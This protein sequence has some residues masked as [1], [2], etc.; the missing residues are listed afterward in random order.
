MW[1]QCA[2][3][4]NRDVKQVPWHNPKT[5]R[6]AFILALLLSFIAGCS[7]PQV[8][9]HLTPKFNELSD[10]DRVRLDQQRAIVAATAKQKN[11]TGGLTKTGADLPI[12]QRLIEDNAFNKTQPYVLQSLGVAFGDDLGR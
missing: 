3:T 8:P 7:K 5:M 2:G 1:N 10:S 11:G 12:L 4:T 9:P 6:A